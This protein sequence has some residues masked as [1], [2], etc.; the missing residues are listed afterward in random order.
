MFRKFGYRFLIIGLIVLIWWLIRRPSEEQVL[1]SVPTEIIV[2]PEDLE[3]PPAIHKDEPQ[4][5]VATSHPRAETKTE[6]IT[7]PRKT[8]KTKTLPADDLKKISGIG[9]KIAGVLQ[10]AGITTFTQLAEM[11]PV[12]IK[13]VL[14]KANIRLAN[15]ET[16][17]EQARQEESAKRNPV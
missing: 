12:E 11:Q 3:T 1:S 10:D 13:E 14:D 16:W 2:P 5:V 9:P 17:P 6:S 4:P 8:A 7:G 15:P